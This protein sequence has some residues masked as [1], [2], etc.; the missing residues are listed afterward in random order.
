MKIG[1][2]TDVHLTDADRPPSKFHNV[3]DFANARANFERAIAAHRAGG[4]SAIVMLGDLA[5]SGDAPYHML[6][7]ELCES[8]GLPLWIVPGNHD[9]EEGASALASRIASSGSSSVRVPTP[10]GETA[11][12]FRVAGLPTDYFDTERNWTVALPDVSAWEREPVLLLSHVPAISRAS[13]AAEAGMN[14][15]G[16]VENHESVADLLRGRGAPTIVLHGHLHLRDATID[17]SVLQIGFASIVEPP[18]ETA[19]V[20]IGIEGDDITVRVCHEAVAESFVDRLPVLAPA[21]ASW[22]YSNGNW[23]TDFEDPES[24]LDD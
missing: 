3:Y 4:V 2:I 5:N 6:R 19:S 20:Q 22:R 17:G 15:A 14:Y 23:Q 9:C 18:H 12:G 16:D 11:G 21:I 24:S 8:A 1:V 13:A 10:G 7:L